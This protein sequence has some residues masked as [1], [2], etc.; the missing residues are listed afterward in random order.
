MR[1]PHPKT[2]VV[3]LLSA[4][5]LALVAYFAVMDLVVLPRAEATL[6]RTE[7]HLQGPGVVAEGERGTWTLR[8]DNRANTDPVR[9]RDLV[10]DPALAEAVRLDGQAL[11]AQGARL[12]G[13][14]IV[15][16]REVP[17]GRSVEVAVP[18]Q[19]R[20]PGRHGGSVRVLFE[21]PRMTKGRVLPL[22]IE[23]R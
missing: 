2:V 21:V 19:A 3:G 5:L 17:G 23:V 11:Q 15:W 18:F 6:D 22:N 16:E 12:E 8:V 4:V 20:R 14:R 9:V 10:L 1:P 13:P 7:V